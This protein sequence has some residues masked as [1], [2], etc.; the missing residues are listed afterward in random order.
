[1]GK[2]PELKMTT[3][4][5]ALARFSLATTETWRTPSGEK[6]Q[7]TEWHNVIVWGKQAEIAEKYL[8]KGKQVMVEGRIQYRDYTDPAGIKKT[9][10]DIRCDSFVMLGRADEGSRQSGTYEKS[11]PQSTHDF[12]D[13]D[14]PPSGQ[15]SFDDDIP[16]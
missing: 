8:R 7:K 11:M 6:Q 1:L 9:F 14:V 2:D 4:G 16:F 10:T 12:E 15:S 13:S 3:S 5:Q